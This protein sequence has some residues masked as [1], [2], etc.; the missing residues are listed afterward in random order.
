MPLTKPKIKSKDSNIL[1]LAIDIDNDLYRK[2]G[3]SGPLMGRVQNLNGASQL[4]L[5]DPE[6][7]DSNTMFYAVHLYDKMKDEG[8]S[9]EVAT[10]TGSEKEGYEAD[11]EV[12]RQL[13][14]VLN[15]YKSDECIL[16][17]DGPSDERVLPII[18]SRVK[19]SSVQQVI[20]KQAEGA[21]N[22]YYAIME[23][24][25]EPH[26]ARTVFGLPA[27][28][29]ILFAVSYFLGTGWILPVALI[30]IYLL[31]KGFGLEEAL[32]NS[33][34]G[35][36][37]SI[38][39]MSFVFYMSA[40]LFAITGVFIAANNYTTK[41]MIT[42]NQAVSIAYMVEGFLVV[43]P[44]I[45]ILYLIGRFIDVRDARYYFRTFKYA[46][47]IGSA[48]IL[49]TLLYSFTEWFMG[50]IYFSQLVDYIIL[51]I[52]IGVAVSGASRVMR[53]RLIRKKSLKGKI[54]VNDLGAMIGK[55]AG[56]DLKRGK[57]IINTGLG[58]PITYSV[59]KIIDLSDKVIIKQ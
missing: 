54:V 4:A 47:F 40:I 5:A 49:W 24:L 51:A 42:G 26:F 46:I 8:Y 11:K 43:L 9:V 55:I 48:I 34:K 3:I 20:I 39:R 15:K 10:V 50:Q 35:L 32:I 36:G 22:T 19:I 56:V 52:L 28:I 27:L 58:N 18:Q 30:G 29:L 6:D 53:R 13:E 44:I 2:T 7:S 14:L 12:A 31:A 17:T 41:L 16:V 1:I 37:F 25:K 59:D 21:E 38:D 45:L 33:F 23:K 57:M